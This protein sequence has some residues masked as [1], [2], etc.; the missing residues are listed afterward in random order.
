MHAVFL[1]VFL[2]S[3]Q[4]NNK[5]RQNLRETNQL[6]Q[7]KSRGGGGGDQICQSLISGTPLCKVAVETKNY[8]QGK[9]MFKKKKI[10]NMATYDE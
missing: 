4:R 1:F 6:I 9:S 7:N 10:T 8:A 3:N 2:S 5:E